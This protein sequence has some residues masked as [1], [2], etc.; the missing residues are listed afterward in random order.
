MQSALAAVPDGGAVLLAVSGGSDSMALV[1]PAMWAARGRIGV[2][3]VT[4]DHGLRPESGAEAKAVG[5]YLDSIVDSAIVTRVVPQGD[6]GPEGNARTARYGRIAQVARAGGELLTQQAALAGP[7]PVLLG[8]TADDQAETVLL[9][10]GRGSGARSIAGMRAR[11]WLPGTDDVPLI[12]PY[13]RLRR[14]DLRQV[15]RAADHPWVEDPTN[16]LNG[17][18]RAADGS[19]LRRSAIRHQVLPALAEVLGESVVD[20]LGRTARMARDDDDFLSELAN[21]LRETCTIEQQSGAVPVVVCKKLAAHPRPLR[22]RLLRELAAQAGGRPG[23]L[24]YG[25][26]AALDRLVCGADNKRQ[27]DLPGAVARREAGIIYFRPE[28]K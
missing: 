11:G 7:L 5:A 25:H 24:V 26:V 19:P 28:E 4:V 8:H 10:L 6:A 16:D 27:I 17:P 3:T 21:S 1:G 14:A 12:R 2:F 9:G 13:L 22:T 23:E 20:S 15:C 18:W